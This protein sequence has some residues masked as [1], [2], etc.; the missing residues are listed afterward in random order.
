METLTKALLTEALLKHGGLKVGDGC[1]G[2]YYLSAGLSISGLML[3]SIYQDTFP[4][5]LFPLVL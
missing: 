4:C 3:R 2:I 5:S 1:Q